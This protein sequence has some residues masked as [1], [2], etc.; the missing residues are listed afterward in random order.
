VS[1]VGKEL[2]EAW[3]LNPSHVSRIVIDL[4][5]G[6]EFVTVTMAVLSGDALDQLTAYRLV[7]LESHP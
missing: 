1:G 7:K 4:S 3:G 2:C 5:P 6:S